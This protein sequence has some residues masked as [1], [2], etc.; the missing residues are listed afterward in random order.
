MCCPCNLSCV[1]GVDTVSTADSTC[2]AHCGQPFIVFVSCV[3]AHRG[4]GVALC[5]GGGCG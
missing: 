4:R 3:S 2:S 1:W 5:G